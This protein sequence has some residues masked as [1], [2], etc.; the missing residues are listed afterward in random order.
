MT[1]EERNLLLGLARVVRAHFRDIGNQDVTTLDGL[2]EPYD[3]SPAPSVA[4][5]REGD[6]LS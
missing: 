4:E 3:A 5:T 6:V 1:P 2:L